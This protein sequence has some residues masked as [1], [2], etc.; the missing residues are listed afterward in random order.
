MKWVLETALSPFVDDR[1]RTDLV[2]DALTVLPSW[3]PLILIGGILGLAVCL[4]LAAKT[5]RRSGE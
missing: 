4:V 5:A 3:Y 1:A 2:L